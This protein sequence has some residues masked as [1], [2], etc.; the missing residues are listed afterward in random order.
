MTTPYN[1][2]MPAESADANLAGA[3]ESL[4][5]ALLEELTDLWRRGQ[6]PDVEQVAS[7]HPRLTAD[8]RSLWATVWV[9]EEMAKNGFG[10]QEP[11][12]D[13]VDAPNTTA[14]PPA[15]ETAAPAMPQAAQHGLDGTL[16]GRF[17]EYE[18]FEEL[19]RGGMGVVS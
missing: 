1:K 3:D 18:L 17:G 13:R 2:M 19:G 9:A 7:R 5:A 15:T 8:L 14:W 12:E 10:E 6:H 16:H 11:V 4:L